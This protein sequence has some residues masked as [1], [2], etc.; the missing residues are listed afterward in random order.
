[1]GVFLTPRFRPVVFTD[2]C[3]V[4]GVG[5]WGFLADDDEA[6]AANSEGDSLA[7][8]ETT[9]PDD[10]SCLTPEDDAAA[11]ARFVEAG[12]FFFF[13]FFFAETDG[14]FDLGASCNLSFSSITRGFRGDPSVD[15]RRL[16]TPLGDDNER[17]YGAGLVE[18]SRPDKV[19]GPRW[20]GDVQVKERSQ[21]R[22]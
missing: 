8:V 17:L 11:V 14:I 21:P 10:G 4:V 2:K 18:L 3:F 7:L 16:E 20:V 13:F 5:G 12:F 19:D 15:K 9:R 1:M 6:E 22:C